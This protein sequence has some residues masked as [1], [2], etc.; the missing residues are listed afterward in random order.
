MDDPTAQS[1]Y[2]RRA[3]LYRAQWLLAARAGADA[4]TVRR[5]LDKFREYATLARAERKCR[6]R[7]G[8]GGVP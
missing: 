1:E 5:L 2:A 7:D 6:E 8:N 4:A 3:S